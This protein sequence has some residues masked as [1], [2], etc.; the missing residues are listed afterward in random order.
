MRLIL[1]RHAKSAW[2]TDGLG[3][4]ARPLAPRGA[5]A[6]P[7]MA[8]DM[9]ARGL[10]PEL[11]LCSAAQRTR[12]TAAALL[13][14]FSHDMRIAVA[15]TLYETNVETL[16]DQIRQT[17]AA[18]RTVLVIGHNPTIQDAALQLAGET[19]GGDI[20][21][22]R[23]KFPAAAYAVLE[24]DAADWSSIAPRGAALVSFRTPA[25]L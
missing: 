5:E 23:A 19:G 17:P 10:E 2:A 14:H 11:V 15:R 18:V 22:L 16:L 20:E 6:A 13:P 12:E 7:R 3:D 8:Q 25:D 21:R 9:V 4:F 24:I 1:M